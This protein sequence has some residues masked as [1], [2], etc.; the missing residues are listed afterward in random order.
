MILYCEQNDFNK[1]TSVILSKLHTPSWG[2][3]NVNHTTNDPII[4]FSTTEN[5]DSDPD[6]K[7]G[8]QAGSGSEI[9]IQKKSESL[10][11]LEVCE[12]GQIHQNCALDF[13]IQ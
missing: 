12:N 1:M 9:R 10:T 5:L 13:G 7:S 6:P 11:S 2:K 3:N 8:S 4:C